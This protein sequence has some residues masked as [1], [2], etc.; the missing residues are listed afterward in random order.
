MPPD[1]Y[2]QIPDE[3][4]FDAAVRSLLARR[5]VE[6]LDFS[7]ALTEPRLYLDT[8]HLNRTGVTEFFEKHLKAI[9]LSPA[10]PQ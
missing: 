4:E 7:G 9:L 2:S 6:F 8:D 5:Q 3:A 1:F 10:G